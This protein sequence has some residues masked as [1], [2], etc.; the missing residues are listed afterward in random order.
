MTVETN[1][2]AR[3][4]RQ[5]HRIN[6]TTTQIANIRST[7]SIAYII[8]IIFIV[9]AM[10]PILPMRCCVSSVCGLVFKQSSTRIAGNSSF[11]KRALAQSSPIRIKS[12]S[13]TSS[14]TPTVVDTPSIVATTPITTTSTTTTT[15]STAPAQQITATMV[16]KTSNTGGLRRLPMVKPPVDLISSARKSLYKVKVDSEMKNIRLRIRKY[17]SETINTLMIALC[18]PLRDIVDGYKREWKRLHP[19]ERVVADLT[20]S[21]HQKKDGLTLPIILSE[22]HEARKMIL[23]AAKDWI[24]KIK[25]AD[26]SRNANLYTEEGIESLIQLYET[27]ASPS[28]HQLMEIQKSLRTTPIVQVDTPA[29]V[30]VGAPNVGKSSIVRAI[31]SATPEVNNYP[32]TTRGMTLGHV[33]VFWSADPTNQ[34][35]RNNDNNNSNNTIVGGGGGGGSHI[36]KA[37]VP[38]PRR[39][40]GSISP[41]VMKGKYAFSQLCQ[42]MDSPGLLVRPDEERNEMEALTL[43]AMQHL[44]TAVCYVMDLTGNAGDKCSSIEDQLILRKE[45]RTRF[46]RR[47]WIDIVSKYDLGVEEDVLRQLE[48]LLTNDDGTKVPYIKLSIHDGTGVQ[49]LRTET[50]RMLSE[51]RVVLDAMAAIQ[52]QQQVVQQPRIQ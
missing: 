33:E 38:D 47:P 13:S 29:V 43:A 36:V 19:F 4:S 12:P 2:C 25:N 6:H 34:F 8:F 28:I 35:N 41:E 45:M 42:I 27:Y 1:A 16:K 52:Q 51:V 39:K 24:F 31:S 22:I 48:E 9:E 3:Y 20:A 40:P 50:L 7:K 32:F 21:S 14:I 18:V 37:M 10:V 30:L 46:P 49:E 17:G 23:E 15:T 44:P 5:T 11:R 26:T